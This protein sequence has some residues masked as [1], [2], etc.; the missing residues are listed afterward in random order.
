MRFV[1]TKSFGEPQGQ[2]APGVS[3][4][5]ALFEG[6]A[7]DGGLYVP[8]SIPRWRPEELGRLP[9]M[10]LPDVGARVLQPFVDELD[11]D[12]LLSIVQEALAF[13]IPLVEVEPGL[14]ALEL[15]HGPTLAFKD[16]GARV[17]ARLMAALFRG[18][19]PLTI[20]VAT[21]G[22][23]GSAVA[24]AFHD[25][26]HTRVAIL[27]PRGRV[28]PTQEAQ[29]TM[30]NSEATNVRA[31]AAAGSFDDCQRLTKA[32]F[33]DPVLSR[34]AN[35]TSA[36]S[37]NIGRLLPQMIYYAHAAGQLA[38]KRMGGAQDRRA[39]VAQDRSAAVAQDFSPAVFSTP[40]GNFGNLTAG[41]M[42]K[43]SGVN[44]GRFVAATNVN[45]VV[46][47]YLATGRFEP[48]PSIHTLA[49]AMDVGNP[50]NFDRLLWLY[51]IDLNAIRHD[52]TGSRH[53]DNEVRAT[54][55]KVYEE[56]GYLLDPHSAIAYLGLV[57][58]ERQEGREGREGQGVFLATAHPAKFA[59]VV[60]P[61]IGRTIPKP[62]P[63]VDALAAKR[64]IL[65][66]DATLEAVEK[67]LA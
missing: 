19:K 41:L 49:N 14:C 36:N 33:A 29:L 64:T 61:I 65:E 48:R 9:S 26:P 24:H 11:Y 37:I 53:D 13:P 28:S 46:P 44:I 25:V 21:S 57:G 62:Q 67:V 31:Y 27:Y 15:F 2:A 16:V 52:V 43:R 18:D 56:R 10:T 23:T 45:D 8:E 60:E 38:A 54:I 20:L 42:A 63:L 17:M 66:I 3:F 50:S 30:F 7:P 22:D 58:R 12:A 4:G 47:E 34:R 39:A 59:E 5:F 6:I 40:S 1:T 35:L 51:G 55:Q 32:A